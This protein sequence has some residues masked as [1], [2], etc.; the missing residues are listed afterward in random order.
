MTMFNDVSGGLR[1]LSLTQLLFAFVACAA[2]VLAQGGLLERR[3]RR[4]AWLLAASG[5]GGFLTQSD[6][7]T[8]AIMLV[9]MAVAAVGIF[10]AI[11]WAMSRLIGVNAAASGSVPPTTAAPSTATARGVTPTEPASSASAAT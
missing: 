4:I 2:Y 1:A 10:A 11:V 9:A 3:G 5:V 8:G 6:E 7:W